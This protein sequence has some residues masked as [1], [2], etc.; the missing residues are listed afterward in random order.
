MKTINDSLNKLNDILKNS[1]KE[2]LDIMIS[3][4]NQLNSEGPKVKEYVGLI[5]GYN[6]E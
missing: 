4:I 6:N 3:T 1:S 5:K 2:R